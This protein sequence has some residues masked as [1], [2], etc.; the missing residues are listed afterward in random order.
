MTY[1]L[2]KVIR[3]LNNW[4]LYCNFN[5][6]L[7][8]D[9]V[10]QAELGGMPLPSSL[11]PECLARTANRARQFSRPRDPT[12]LVFEVQEDHIPADFLKGDVIKHGG[13]HLIFATGEQLRL[14]R[15]AKSWYIDQ[16][17]KC[18]QHPFKQLLT[19]SAFVCSEDDAKQV[20]LAFVLMSGSE[21]KDYRKVNV[22]IY[23]FIYLFATQIFQ[24]DTT[25]Q[26]SKPNRS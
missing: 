14:L 16:T 12:S 26:G 15:K 7:D 20:P 10:L 9:Q 1:P 13:R 21:K 3:P 23:L 19:I 6:R 17:F 11:K 2:D 8:F 22:C 4:D 5:Y 25:W 18:C 24:E